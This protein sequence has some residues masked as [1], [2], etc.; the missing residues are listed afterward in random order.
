M[1]KR[2]GE[3][4]Y[5]LLHCDVTYAIW[6][7]FFSCFGL[8]W[9]INVLP[10]CMLAGCWSTSSS[11]ECCSVENGAFVHFIVFMEGRELHKF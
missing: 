9:V 8:S 11:S 2:N 10:I 6:I 1:C 3:Y 4:A 7:A 5:H